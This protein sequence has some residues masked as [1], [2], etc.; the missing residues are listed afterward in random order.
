[1]TFG[2]ISFCKRSK[3]VRGGAPPT[4]R[5]SSWEHGLEIRL[6]PTVV[7][8][9]GTSLVVQGQDSAASLEHGFNLRLGN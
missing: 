1:M 8:A 4:K 3:Y 6:I 7:I 2:W 5:L 9:V